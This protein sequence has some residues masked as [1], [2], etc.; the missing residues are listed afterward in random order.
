VNPSSGSGERERQKENSEPKVDSIENE[1][2]VQ[3]QELRQTTIS[4][5]RWQFWKSTPAKE[6]DF[7]S[8]KIGNQVYM[9]GNLNVDKFRNGDPIPEAKTDSEWEK[10]GEKK[11]PAW[12]YYKNDEKNGKIYGRL[13][14]WY[15]VNDLRGLAPEGWNIPSDDEWTILTT[16]LGGDG[17]AGGKM[18]STGSHYWKS[19]NKDASN[20]SGFS[21][22]P[23]GGCFEN[24]KFSHIGDD[25]DWWSSSESGT[26]TAWFRG[27]NSGYGKVYRR[28]PY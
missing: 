5:K 13:Y 8:V 18:K 26:Y 27:L 21:G 23:G 7:P 12:C 15:A 1:D 9:T 24:G 14:N 6:T 28:D 2:K 25:G 16:H 20:S 11:Q 17:S 3:T 4:K 10:A 22:L 19:P